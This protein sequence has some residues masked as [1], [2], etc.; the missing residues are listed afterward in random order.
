MGCCGPTPAPIYETADGRHMAV[1]A[2]EGQFWKTL[3]QHLGFEQ[4]TGLQYDEKRREEI[5][6]A[7]R[8]AFI[9]KTM[10][11]WE[12]EFSRMDVC[13]SGINT[14]EEVLTAPLFRERK[15]VVELPGADGKPEVALGVPVKL[16][17]TP[18]SVRTASIGFGANTEAILREYGYTTEEIRQFAE[19]DVI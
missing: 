13:V 18:G 17:E 11:Q 4:Y 2:V 7:F 12:A 5:I 6:A 9:Q 8:Q 3:C 19:G 1:G 14:L 10:A 16:S 15:M